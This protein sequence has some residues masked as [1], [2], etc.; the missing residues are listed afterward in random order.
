MANV[1]KANGTYEAY[2][3]NKVLQSINRSGIP[4][5]F[6]Q[7]V[8]NHVNSKIYENIPTKEIYGHVAE[9]LGASE[10]PYA[11]S[12][13]GLKQAIMDLGPTGYPFE[14]FVSEVLISISVARCC[15]WVTRIKSPSLR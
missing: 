12:S 9:F 2:N 4:E 1:L 14:D 13:Y 8:L 11:K 7:D 3:E 6:K 15:I 5:S 10:Y